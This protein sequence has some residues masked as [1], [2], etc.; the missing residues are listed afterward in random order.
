MGATNFNAFITSGS[1]GGPT[2]GVRVVSMLVHAKSGVRTEITVGSGTFT[3]HKLVYGKA[4][5]ASRDTQS[6]YFGEE[7]VPIV[8][9]GYVRV[10]GASGRVGIVWRNL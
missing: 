6:L 9:R 5:E 2:D 8:G 4:V 3:Q 1:F 10:S 7:G